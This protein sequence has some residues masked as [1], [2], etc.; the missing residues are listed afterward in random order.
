MASNKQILIFIISGVNRLFGRRFNDPD[1]QSDIKHWPFKVVQG[2]DD[3]PKIQVKAKGETKTFLPEEISSMVL[4]KM[5]ETAEAFL[6]QTVTN[7][8]ISVPVGFN[9]IQ[10]Q[11]VKDA[12]TIAGNNSR[13]LQLISGMIY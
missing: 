10:R 8:V 12:A 3:R 2:E 4:T 5:K 6:G 1:V 7:A 11:A 9:Y 13:F